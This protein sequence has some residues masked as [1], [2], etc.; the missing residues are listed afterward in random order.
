MNDD[1]DID[2]LMSSVLGKDGTPAVFPTAPVRPAPARPA[3][4]RLRLVTAED[5]AAGEATTLSLVD[6]LFGTP[7]PSTAREPAPRPVERQGIAGLSGQ[8][9]AVLA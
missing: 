1:A 2:E 8:L 3:A 7:S 9:A 5:Q 6:G 4:P